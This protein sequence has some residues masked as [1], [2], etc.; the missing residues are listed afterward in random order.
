[1]SDPKPMHDAQLETGAHLAM[2]HAVEA[3]FQEDSEGEA[4]IARPTLRLHSADQRGSIV[5]IAEIVLA[6]TQS[7]IEVHDCTCRVKAMPERVNY[8]CLAPV[9]G[10]TGCA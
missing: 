5:P 1:M 8:A 6:A 9:C 10:G 4:A 7:D 2:A 3:V